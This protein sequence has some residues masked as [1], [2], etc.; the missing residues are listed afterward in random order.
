MRLRGL[1]LVVRYEVELAQ[2]QSSVPLPV[3]TNGRLRSTSFD[4]DLGHP[5]SPPFLPDTPIMTFSI[6]MLTAIRYLLM[7]V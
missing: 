5:S 6:Y 2:T 7:S 1:E 3:H 4:L